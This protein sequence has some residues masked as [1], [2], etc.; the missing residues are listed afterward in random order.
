M[1]LSCLVLLFSLC[2]LN[3]SFVLFASLFVL[4]LLPSSPAL[5]YL[6]TVHPPDNNLLS[7]LIFSITSLE[8]PH[9]PLTPV[10][11]F[12]KF[13]SNFLVQFFVLCPAAVQCECWV[14]I[15]TSVFHVW[16]FCSTFFALSVLSYL[17]LQKPF[18]YQL[19]CFFY[20]F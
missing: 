7:C 13:R 11:L 10:S 3:T 17:M 16:H 18:E 19:L 20:L 6:F 5:H 4:K 8:L 14:G 2:L 9:L 12:C 15:R 1:S